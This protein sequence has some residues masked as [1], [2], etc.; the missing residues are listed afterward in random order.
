MLRRLVETGSLHLDAALAAKVT[1]SAD[2]LYLG[3]LVHAFHIVE[4]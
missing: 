2:V 4:D 3:F 1:V